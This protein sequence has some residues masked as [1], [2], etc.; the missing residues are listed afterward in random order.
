MIRLTSNI[1]TETIDDDYFEK[2]KS[3]GF[4]GFSVNWQY[5]TQEFVQGA[6]RNGMKVYVWTLND[7]PDIAG[8]ALLGV[9]GVITDDPAATIKLLDSLTRK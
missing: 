7:S 1:P 3:L 6:Q 2:M 5:L 4:S 8:A 9:D